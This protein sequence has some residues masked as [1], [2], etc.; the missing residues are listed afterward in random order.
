MSKTLVIA[1]E[2]VVLSAVDGSFF[3]APACVVVKG[4][5][6]ETVACVERGMAAESAK[7]LARKLSAK[8]QDFGSLL[9][10]P[11]F[12]NAHTHLPMSFFRGFTVNESTRKN[13]IEDLFYHVESRLSE[14]DVLAFTRMGAYE[15][16]A[17]GVGF[18]W[19]HYYYGRAV[20]QGLHDVG[21]AGVVAPTLQDLSGPGTR[22]L[23]RQWDETFEIA[24]S[25][26]FAQAGIFSAFGPHATD[27]V[28]SDLWKRIVLEAKRTDFPIHF[29]LAQSSEE[30]ARVKSREGKSPVSYL[31]DLGVLDTD[32]RSLLVHNIYVPAQE[33]SLLAAKNKVLVFCPFSQLIFNFPASALEWERAGVSW[34]VATDC[35]ASNDSMNMQKELRYVG[36]LANMQ[37][38]YDDTYRKFVAHG[39]MDLVADVA[40]I[41]SQSQ[42]LSMR[43]SNADFL[44][45]KAWNSTENLHPRCRVGRLAAGYLANILVWDNQHPSLW[46][47]TQE[48]RSLAMGD[49]SLAIYN[50]MVSG[51]WLGKDGNY[52][53]SLVSSDAYQAARCEA[54]E[55]LVALQKRL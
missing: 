4:N 24:A 52:A 50:M 16:L 31:K 51:K 29:H 47:A 30:Y 32:V 22:W 11:A 36:G 35:V 19:D 10:S 34:T 9:V 5:R 38:T 41:R 42:D 21:L 7:A 40:R 6:I 43:F 17:N 18:V 12:V 14:E 15:C 27:T 49:S 23:E 8:V 25:E 1:S 28:S 37:V 44:L 3:V 13:M 46:P 53:R 26:R 48:L 45:R 39:D 20:A 55:R 54:D 2:K 33:L